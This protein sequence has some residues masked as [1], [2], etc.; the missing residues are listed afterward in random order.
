MSA[1]RVAII[2]YGAGNIFSVQRGLKS[3]GFEPVIVAEPKLLADFR[4]IVLPGVGAFGEGM[5]K[6]RDAGFPDAVARHTAAGK[7]LLGI[8]L[9]AQLLM[10][11]SEEF[12]EHQ[13]LGLIGGRVL[14]IPPA[15]RLRIPHVGWAPVECTG[16]GRATLFG[17]VDDHDQ[18]YFVHSFSCVPEN[19]SDILATFTYGPHRLVAAVGRGS[20]LGVQFHT[21]LS[22]FS[23]R[24]ILMRFK[25]L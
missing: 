12:G 21:E 4:H 24:K 16:Q 15:P 9:G 13:G 8:C 18:F 19:D 5:A 25:D 23:G 7:P 20:V 1:P 2:D 14:A 17:D 10:D 3:I 11:A 6:L 22:S